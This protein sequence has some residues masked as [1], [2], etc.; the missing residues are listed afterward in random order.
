[1]ASTFSV[2]IGD[3]ILG[4]Y[5]SEA[6]VTKT[7]GDYRANN[8][9]DPKLTRVTVQETS[10]DGTATDERSVWDFVEAEHEPPSS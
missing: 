6:D 2:T 9:N 10:D 4:P 3:E 5:T 8:P 1:M 7:L